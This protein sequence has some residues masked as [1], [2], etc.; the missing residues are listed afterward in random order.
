[1]RGPIVTISL[2]SVVGNCQ[3]FGFI[4]V[5]FRAIESNRVIRLDD[6]TV[7]VRHPPLLS[8]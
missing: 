4:V 6:G 7:I 3:Y 1:M 8:T 5:E 2:G